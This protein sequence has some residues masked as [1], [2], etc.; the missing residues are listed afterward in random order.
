M[1]LHTFSFTTKLT[2]RMQSK[3]IQNVS[4]DNSISSHQDLFTGIS[5][6]IQEIGKIHY[7]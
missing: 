6:H 7:A 2:F 1:T 3:T 5:K 4:R